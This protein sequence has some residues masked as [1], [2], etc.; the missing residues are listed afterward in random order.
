MCWADRRHDLRLA[1]RAGQGWQNY[2]V[3]KVGGAAVTIVAFIAGLFVGS[4]LGAFAMA[5]IAGSRVDVP[6]LITPD[7][8]N[9][10]DDIALLRSHLSSALANAENERQR[11]DT[12]YDLFCQTIGRKVTA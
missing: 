6:V 4:T 2:A 11:A 1:I 5:F 12:Y 3:R 9:T 8:P 10:N 7:E